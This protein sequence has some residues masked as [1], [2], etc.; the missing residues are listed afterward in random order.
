[1]SE[2]PRRA[3]EPPFE[4]FLAANGHALLRLAFLLTGN[5]HDADDLLQDTLT[6]IYRHWT[7][8][9]Q[10]H[11]PHAY[12]RRMLVNRHTSNHRRR[13]STERPIDPASIREARVI[14]DQERVDSDQ[15]LWQRLSILA[16]RMRDVLV[17]RYYADLDDAS[18]GELLGIRTGTVRSTAA[19]AL[20]ILREEEPS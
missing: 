4:A 18:I 9:S 5:R 7:K 1:V 16:P 3:P 2:L 14:G 8:V 20:A 12:A 13:S 19:R 11:V 6:D 17:L 15:A 10:S